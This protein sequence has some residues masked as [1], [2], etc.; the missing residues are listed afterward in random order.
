[1]LY[2]MDL[3]CDSLGKVCWDM[4]EV[5]HEGVYVVDM[6]RNILFWNS[7]AEKISGFKHAEVLGKSCAD[8]IL[9]H[10]ADN[11][12]PLCL[13]SCPIAE[14]MSDGK[15]RSAKVYLHHRDGHRV[16]VEVNVY[17]LSKDG[18]IFGAIEFFRDIS[19]SRDLKERVIELEQK[20]L[21]DPLT[22]VGN[23]RYI[24]SELEKRFQEYER[25][26]WGFAV[27]MCDIDNFKY[28]NDT[29]GHAVGD[30]VL[31]MVAK[32]L[33]SATR[34]FD[35]VG[36]YGGEEFI[37]IISGVQSDEIVHKICERMRSLVASSYL[38]FDVEKVS[39]SISIGAA[40]VRP[41]S[42]VESL[43]VNADMALLES[44]VNGKNKVTFKE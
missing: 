23:R 8:N 40:V 29:F 16:P 24:E 22:G 17:P 10:V 30:D 36:R 14:S 15:K 39:V 9:M 42:T 34:A 3:E 43:V 19:A 7:Q 11:G 21:L 20:S 41:Y 18:V 4:L 26:G 5:V 37:A 28:V 31:R 6:H 32:S 13:S 35:F 12:E 1:M 33:V 44:K 2:K 38:H 25:Y 27:A